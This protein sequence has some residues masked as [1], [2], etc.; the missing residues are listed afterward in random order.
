MEEIVRSLSGLGPTP[1]L[2]TLRRALPD[3]Q[4]PPALRGTGARGP[5]TPWASTRGG[6]LNVSLHSLSGA[7][8]RGEERDEDP[9][10]PGLPNSDA[11]EGQGG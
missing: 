5:L 9:L 7:K 4:R 8:G 1:T 2:Q 10:K 3:L 11:E 6:G